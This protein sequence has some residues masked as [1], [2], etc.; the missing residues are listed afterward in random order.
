VS[1]RCFDDGGEMTSSREAR[2]GDEVED[3]E[4]QVSVAAI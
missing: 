4:A 2:L 1:R 3:V